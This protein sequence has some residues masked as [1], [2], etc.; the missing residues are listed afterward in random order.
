MR[1]FA[2][3][4]GLGMGNAMTQSEVPGAQI[5]EL[6]CDRHRRALSIGSFERR[7]WRL[8]RTPAAMGIE[9]SLSLRMT[10][11]MVTVLALKPSLKPWCDH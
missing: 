7:L 2:R 1:E 10:V 4:V 9:S 3:L 5:R 11:G 6:W 8:R